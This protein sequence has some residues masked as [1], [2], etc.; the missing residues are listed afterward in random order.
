M[1]FY[2]FK[3]ILPLVI[4]HL[5]TAFLP[6]LYGIFTGFRQIIYKLLTI[7][8]Y[9]GRLRIWMSETTKG[10]EKTVKWLPKSFGKGIKKR[11]L[12]TRFCRRLRN[13]KVTKR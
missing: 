13:I 7:E 9:P 11:S 4:K 12:R 6:L 5:H 2:K 3:G 1:N 8:F 10:Y